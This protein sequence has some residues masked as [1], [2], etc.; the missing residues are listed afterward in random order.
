MTSTVTAR[1]ALALLAS[2]A[3]AA[4]AGQTAAQAGSQQPPFTAGWRDGFNIQ[5]ENGDYRLQIGLVAQADGRFVLEDA[6]EAVVDTFSIRKLR[7]G[8]SGRVARY[9][10][11]QVVPDFG[12]GQAVLVDAFIDI[13]FSPALRVRSGKAKTPIGYEVLIGDPFV[14]FPERALASSLIP[15]R[16]VGFQALGDLAGGRVFYQGGVVNGIPDGSNSTSDLDANDGKDLAGRIVL[17]PFRTT[18]TPAPPLNGLGFALGGSRG[19]QSGPLPQFRTSVGQRYF[20]YDAAAAA[21]GTRSRVTPSVFYYYKAFGAFAEYVQSTQQVAR[22]AAREEITNDAWEVTASFVVTGEASSDRGVRP[23]ANFD[24]AAGEWGA[25]QVLTRYSELSIDSDAFDAALAAAG[26]SGHATQFSV[27]A[28][29]YPAPFLKYYL[30][31]E[32]IGFEG[33]NASRPD[34]NSVILRAQIAF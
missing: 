33:G 4:A 15:N 9:F 19:E 14:L 28:N 26:S 30:A 32:R 24:P 17:Q 2:I 34:E 29:W 8:F 18:A 22:G 11:F 13:R 21:A 3:P 20:S 12:S 5:T 10:D 7:P 25:L 6:T 31:Y 27:G 1:V 23:R 16:D